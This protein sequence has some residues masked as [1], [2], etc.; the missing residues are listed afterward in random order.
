MT[1]LDWVVAAV[2]A[3]S[4]LLG[5]WRGLMRELFSLAGWVGGIVLAVRFA[6]SLGQW[7][8]RDFGWPALRTGLAA[9]AIVVATVFAAAALGW[10]VRRLLAAARLSGTDRAL[11]ALFGLLRGILLVGAAVFLASRT[12][13]A[14]QPAWQEARLLGLFDAGVRLLAPHLP[15][16][17]TRSGDI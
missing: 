16:A 12:A 7:L 11:G 17:L 4:A 13:L 10:I 14:Q 6:E 9:F 8:P 5:L 3:A 1:T 2:L 15:P